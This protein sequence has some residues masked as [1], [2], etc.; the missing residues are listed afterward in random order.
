MPDHVFVD[1][2]KARGL[3]VAAAVVG[4]ADVVAHRRVLRGLLLPGQRR[5][6]FTKESPARRRKIIDAVVEIDPVVRL[7]G[8]NRNDAAARG[9]CLTA[10]IRD[11]AGDAERVV[12]ERDEST[13]DF[14]RRSLFEA[15]R[16]HGCVATL[17]YAVAPAHNDPLLWVPDA[18]AWCWS[19][20]GEWR[21]AVAGMC[22]EKTL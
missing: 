18:V 1:E 4:A 3:L 12:V 21:A 11:A 8:A 15:V 7:Y 6:H 14:D 13:A 10:V 16:V 9:S 5:L 22:V 17:T 2:S 20:G 19:T